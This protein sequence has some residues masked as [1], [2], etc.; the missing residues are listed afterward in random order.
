MRK[1]TL[2]IPK[3]PVVAAAADSAGATFGP[4]GW[5]WS[6]EFPDTAID[7]LT[8][9]ANMFYAAIATCP[10]A[11]AFSYADGPYNVAILTGAIYVGGASNSFTVFAFNAAGDQLGPIFGN[12]SD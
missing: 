8:T 11:V 1:I 6:G 2:K 5:A 10:G 7:P 12:V 4:F 9:D 3:L